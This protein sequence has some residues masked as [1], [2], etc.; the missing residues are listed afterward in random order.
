M[1]NT[2]H[3]VKIQERCEV[4]SRG[5]WSKEKLSLEEGSQFSSKF[6]ACFTFKTDA[7]CTLW[8]IQ[9]SLVKSGEKRFCLALVRF[10]GH[11]KSLKFRKQ[12]LEFRKTGKLQ[13]TKRWCF[14][15]E[16][17]VV[18]VGWW[19]IGGFEIWA[20]PVKSRNDVGWKYGHCDAKNCFVVSV[21]DWSLEVSV[22]IKHPVLATANLLLNCKSLCQQILSK[23]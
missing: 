13:G 3:L 8:A 19:Y 20:L 6:L 1:H 4:E 14:S 9:L 7:K 18:D 22:G 17:C 5:R 11:S 15:A 21:P 10:K 12:F 16:V 23:V 2:L